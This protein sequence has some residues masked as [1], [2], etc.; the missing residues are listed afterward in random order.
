MVLDPKI[1]KF[2]HDQGYATFAEV[3]AQYPSIG[4]QQLL[5]AV[6]DNEIE[7]RYFSTQTGNWLA[8]DTR[9]ANS[10]MAVH[11]TQISNL[12]P[13]VPLERIARDL[14]LRYT[15]PPL[16]LMTKAEEAERQIQALHQTAEVIPKPAE[17]P[18][19]AEPSKEVVQAVV[20]PVSQAPS[21]DDK[22]ATDKPLLTGDA[23]RDPLR[24]R[25]VDALDHHGWTLYHFAREMRRRG[26]DCPPQIVL[27]NFVWSGMK[28]GDRVMARLVGALD[29]L[30]RSDQSP[31]PAP[32]SG[33]PEPSAPK[34]EPKVPFLLLTVEED[35]SMIL[36][37]SSLRL[38]RCLV[39]EAKM[40]L[41]DGMNLVFMIKMV[42]GK[43]TFCLSDQD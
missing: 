27:Q 39:S 31:V 25:L 28:I 3:T 8:D 34:S 18:S 11:I 14:Q 23:E 26:V 37:G 38:G 17:A 36:Q 30:E 4:R 32:A 16:S 7:I 41:E 15:K 5:R 22:G 6:R 29:A 1:P 9:L 33:S 21:G 12:L 42:D 19:P 13:T 10:D 43:P 40:P 20:D 35:G 24:Q 2:L